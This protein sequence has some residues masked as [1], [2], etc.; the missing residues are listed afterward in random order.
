M[1]WYKGGNVRSCCGNE[2]GDE[3]FVEYKMGDGMVVFV[4]EWVVT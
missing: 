2:W 1:V 4:I 3:W